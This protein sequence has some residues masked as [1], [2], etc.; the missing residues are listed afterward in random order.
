MKSPFEPATGKEATVSSKRIDDIKPSAPPRRRLTL[1]S[2]TAISLAT[3]LL[4]FSLTLVNLKPS[5]LAGNIRPFLG[6]WNHQA[7]LYALWNEFSFVIVAPGPH[8]LVPTPVW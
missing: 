8:V 5:S 2:A 1:A 7:L 3:M 6:G 4:C